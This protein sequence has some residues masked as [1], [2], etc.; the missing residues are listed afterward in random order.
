TGPYQMEIL[1]TTVNGPDIF[2]L[3]LAPA[4]GPNAFASTL[5]TRGV[6]QAGNT[7]AF[8]N[9]VTLAGQGRMRLNGNNITIAS[10]SGGTPENGTNCLVWNNSTTTAATLTVGT[11]GSSTTFEGIFGDGNAQPL[12]LTKF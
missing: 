9:A 8:T 11:D 3:T 7:N 2:V 10:L 5:V 12:G 1:G 6:L 4:N